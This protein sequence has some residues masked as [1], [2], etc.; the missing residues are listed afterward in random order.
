[1]VSEKINDKVEAIMSRVSDDFDVDKEQVEEKVRLMTEEYQV[2]DSEVERAVLTSLAN[3]LDVD[4]D[5]LVGDTPDETPEEDREAE[6]VKISEIE[7]GGEWVTLEA[8]VVD[9][10]DNNSDKVAQRGL[11]SDETGRVGFV[12]WA[13]SNPQTLVEGQHYRIENAVT[14]YSEESGYYS[15]QINSNTDIEMIDREPQEVGGVAVS[16]GKDTGLVDLDDDEQTV[17]LR[18]ALDDGERIN[19]VHLDEEQT[20]ELTGVGLEEAREIARETLERQDVVEEMADKVLGRF[21]KADVVVE[22]GSMYM[23]VE[24]IEQDDE[25]GDVDELLARARS[26]NI[27]GDNNE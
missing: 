19:R 8:M 23:G 25:V 12:S 27:T 7:E 4:K 10:W 1:M 5:E 20:E 14:D 22:S 3:E 16:L 11:L 6:E 15:V 18:L 21:F 17:Q 13:K 9:I 26:M 2:A 24:S